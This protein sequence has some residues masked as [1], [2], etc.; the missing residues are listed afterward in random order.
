MCGIAGIFD[1]KRRAPIDGAMLSKMTDILTHRGP[2]GSGF[3]VRDGIGLG[4]RRLAIVDIPGGT[5]PFYNEDDSVCVVFNGEIYNFQAL[6]RELS[7]RGHT[8]RTRSDTEVIVHAWEEWG[9]DCAARLNGMFAFAVWDANKKTLFLARDRLGEKPLYYSLLDTGEFIF[10][11]E[12][13]SLLCHP[14]LSRAIDARAIEDYFAYG[15]VPD[16][17]SIYRSV[18]K[19]PPAHF[20][21][22]QHGQEMTLPRAY[23]EVSF[24]EDSR[25]TEDALREEL[26]T[27]LREAVRM[28]LIADVPLGA[29]LSGGVDSSATVAMM[30]SIKSEPTETFSIG[31][32]ARQY[33][34]SAY[35]AAVAARYHTNHHARRVDSNSF[36][37]VDKLAAI[38]DEPFGDSSAIPTF[39]VSA[40][41]REHVTVALSGDGGDEL[42]AGYRRYRWHVL[43]ERVRRRLPQGIRGPLFSSLGRLYPKL[44]WAPRLF[45]A[46]A[47]FQEL[48]RS[49]V[50]GYFASVSVCSDEL[51][52]RLFSAR[53]A[54]ELQGYRAIE[55]LEGHSS[56]AG[57]DDP[58]AQVQYLDLKTYL[59]GDILTKVDRAS[60]ANSL[61]VRVP[62]LDHTL[63]EWAA[64]VPATL[65]LRG[66][67]GKYILKAAMRPYLPADILYRPK[68]G[69]AVP[70][71]NWF[72]GP[73]RDRLRK[74][75]AGPMLRESGLFNM[76]FIEELLDRHQSG[77][78]DHSASLWSLLLFESFLRQSESSTEGAPAAKPNLRAVA[79]Q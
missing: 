58:L 2:D 3:H 64:R 38:Y 69:F 17:R 35:A 70:L 49:S 57:T 51:R 16:P 14:R 24:L 6:A 79:A 23:W 27:R 71:A 25:L 42:F 54:H 45:R 55:V 8:F 9:P 19:L 56:N 60:M 29:F 13:K 30:A 46:K 33:D 28:R 63:V 21:M 78:R 1:L 68:Q 47:T 18:A 67:E 26:V 40:M 41:T 43:E 52:R 36:D 31:F 37:L 77:A 39:Q 61:E 62:F 65:K 7:A 11:S 50:G 12:L 22:L 75:L 20:L 74:A 10:G 34:E 48:A 53:L 72:R 73:L 32:G 5:Q 4:S 44:D 76:G 59:P 15:Y 66:R